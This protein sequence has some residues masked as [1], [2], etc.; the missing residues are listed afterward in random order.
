MGAIA[1]RIE[2]IRESFAPIRP[3]LA[4]CYLPLAAEHRIDELAAAAHTSAEAAVPR[5]IAAR[6]AADAH[7]PFVDLAPVIAQLQ[8]AKEPITLDGDAHYNART[9]EAVG[10]A[11][12]EGTDWGRAAG[13]P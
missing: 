8:G 3:G 9:S 13:R 1:R 2:S 6:L 7:A 10:R 12:W 11:L 5:R 4:F